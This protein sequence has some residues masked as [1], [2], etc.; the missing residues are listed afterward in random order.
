[1][2]VGMK[3]SEQARR[4]WA[5][6]S[7]RELHRKILARCRD[8]EFVRTFGKRQMEALRRECMAVQRHLDLQ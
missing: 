3:A 4:R 7:L 1:M 8:P 6:K 2:I 5:N